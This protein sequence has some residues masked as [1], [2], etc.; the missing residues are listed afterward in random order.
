MSARVSLKTLVDEPICFVEGESLYLNRKTGEI[1]HVFEDEMEV[2][3]EFPG[4]EEEFAEPADAKPKATPNVQEISESEDYIALPTQW[5]LDEYRTMERFCIA[6][7]TPKVRDRL[8]GVIRG[9]GAFRRFKNAIRDFGLEKQWYEYRDEAIK[10]EVIGWC[11]AY[12]IAF[13]P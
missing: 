13:D 3:L 2:D 9:S 4:D 12:G 10:E 8:L 5:N 6:V 1:V 11:E 7:E